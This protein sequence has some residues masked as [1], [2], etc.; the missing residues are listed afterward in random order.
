META[1]PS[2][3]SNHADLVRFLP[4]VHVIATI[5]ADEPCAQIIVFVRSGIDSSSPFYFETRGNDHAFG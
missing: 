3:L 4:R 1:F 5:V 2:V